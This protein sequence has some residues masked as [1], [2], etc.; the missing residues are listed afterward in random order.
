M[1]MH[2]CVTGRE[3]VNNGLLCLL[4]GRALAWNGFK[5]IFEVAPV[6]V[7][8]NEITWTDLNEYPYVLEPRREI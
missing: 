6:W 1:L 5:Q 8:I 3:R 4:D 2:I 7:Q